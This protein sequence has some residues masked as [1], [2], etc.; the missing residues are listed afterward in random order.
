MKLSRDISMDRE[1]QKAFIGK[2]I[3]ESVSIGM[4]G[5]PLMAIREY[6]Q[7]SADAID[8]FYKTATSGADSDGEI[9]ITVD[10]RRKT[11]EI[12]DRG[13]GVSSEKARDILHGLGKSDKDP[14]LNRG[15]RGIGRLGGLGYC[16]ELRFTTKAK[17]QSLV[18]TNIW[19]CEELKQ[20]INGDNDLLD[21]ATIVNRTTEFEQHKYPG[22]LDDHF[23]IVEM[24][25]VHNS[26]NWLLNV[27]AVKSYVSQVAPVPFHPTSFSFGREIDEKLR[28][29][30]PFY[31]TYPIFVNGERVYKPYTDAVNTLRDGHDQI[32]DVKFYMLLD[33]T[34]MLAFGWLADLSFLG[35]LNPTALVDGVRVRSG[36]IL[37]GDK[38]LLSE[39]YRESRFS[40][41]MVGEIHVVDKRLIPNSR[42]DDFED[43]DAKSDFYSS[44]IREIGIPYSKKIREL[45][46]CR[47]KI[48]KNAHIESLYG[49]AQR[50]SESG[51]V[52]E[53]QKQEIVTTLQR[54][55][56]AGQGL[57]QTEVE[58]LLDNVHA[59]KHIVDN[60][61]SVV[62]QELSDTYKNIFEIIYREAANKLEA[63]AIIATILSEAK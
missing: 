2:Y 4:Y 21:S 34:R 5:H 13:C 62:P 9:E 40:S 17:G 33:G 30:V 52:A 47:S 11:V 55:G 10:G 43:N 3:L 63:E 31:A 12:K 36:N 6:I 29:N 57:P 38:N 14:L 48:K 45:S 8:E 42:R 20:F 59:S 51:Y 18:S 49:R 53:L 35:V 15:F 56:G 19:N 7:N 28:R 25:G 26:R 22:P 23:F 50:V 44:F 41:Y 24:R 37:I 39:F 16:R 1:S 46:E 54:I 32:G 58:S 60:G 27:P 61:H